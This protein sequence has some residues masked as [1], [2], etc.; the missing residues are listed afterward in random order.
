MLIM[1]HKDPKIIEYNIKLLDC[2]SIDF[3]L[4]I[5]KKSQMDDFL[6]LKSV[7]KCSHVYFIPRL[8][9]HWG[10]QNQIKAELALFQTAFNEKYDYYHLISGQDLIVKSCENFLKFFKENQQDFLKIER[11]ANTK[12]MDRIKYYHPIA[13]TKLSRSIIGWKI[14]LLLVKV[15]KLFNVNRCKK[16]SVYAGENW[17]SL[18]TTFVSFLL[19]KNKDGFISKY[20]YCSG[21]ADE[22]YKQTI[23][24]MWINMSGL[25]NHTN[26]PIRYVDWSENKESPKVLN[27]EDYGKINSGKYLFARK[28]TSKNNLPQKVFNNLTM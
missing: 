1:A 7:P 8:N 9:I 21:N 25:D 19:S 28:V 11:K 22:L 18:T 4:H 10:G 5:D 20:F 2:S 3:Y 27:I 13:Q 15:Q 23:Y 6:F 12:K 14:E 17:C 26:T 16:L 24:E